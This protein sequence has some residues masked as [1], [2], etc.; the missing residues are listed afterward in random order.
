MPDD[1]ME[2]VAPLQKADERA[3]MQFDYAWNWF[4]FHAEQRTRMFNYMLIGMGIFATALVAAIDKKLPVEAITIGAAAMCV[5]IVFYLIDRRNRQLYLVAMDVLIH[6]ERT[7]MFGEATTFPDHRHRPRLFGISGRVA[8]ED[9]GLMSKRLPDLR[10]ALSGQHRHWIPFIALG[11]GALFGAAAVR[12]Y[13]QLVHC[14]PKWPVAAIGVMLFVSCGLH[15]AWSY[16]R[17]TKDEFESSFLSSCGF[18]LGALLIALA[19]LVPSFGEP[20][21][22]RPQLESSVVTN[23]GDATQARVLLGT[24]NQVGVIGSA[25]F[26]GYGP[27]LDKLDCGTPDN[28]AATRQIQQWLNDIRQRNEQPLL[29]LVGS[30]DPRAATGGAS[31]RYGIGNGPARARTD[32]AYACLGRQGAMAAPVEVLHL[33]GEP[34]VAATPSGV[35]R[36]SSASVTAGVVVR[37]SVIAFR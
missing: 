22:R 24:A 20:L 11:F 2:Q 30:T 14:A 12:G 4:E 10:G 32:A 27:A 26:K 5:A 7:V 8:A 17:S 31:R 36:P 25:T 13:L 23:L 29:I 37:A 1:T 16:W 9:Q 19:L 21:E 33:A 15:F 18:F 28:Q 35:A 34:N 6:L 3:R